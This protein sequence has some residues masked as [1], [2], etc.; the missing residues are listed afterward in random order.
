MLSH[1]IEQ[2]RRMLKLGNNIRGFGKRS[3]DAD[4]EIFG[5]PLT[6][7]TRYRQILNPELQFEQGIVH[8]K[9]CPQN[10]LFWTLIC[11]DNLCNLLLKIINIPGREMQYFQSGF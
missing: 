4:F 5:F 7:K 6:I 1:Y 10:P 8:K 2:P 9:M 11:N 3:C